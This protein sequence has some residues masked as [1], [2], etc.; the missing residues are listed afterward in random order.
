MILKQISISYYRQYHRI[1][2]RIRAIMMRGK[3]R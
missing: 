2:I 3:L 1:R